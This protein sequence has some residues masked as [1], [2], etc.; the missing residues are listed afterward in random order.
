MEIKL[1]Y[2]KDYIVRA[3]QI[4]IG[5]LLSRNPV[6]RN[7]EVKTAWVDSARLLAGSLGLTCSY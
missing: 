6:N 1:G 2:I 4:L 3:Q 5:F 7:S